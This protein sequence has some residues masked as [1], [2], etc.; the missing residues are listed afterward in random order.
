MSQVTHPTVSIQRP[1]SRNHFVLATCAALALVAAIAAGM[2]LSSGSA[3]SRTSRIAPVSRAQWPNE[4]R[5]AQAVASA[6]VHGRR[7]SSA[8]A[9]SRS[10]WPNEVGTAQAVGRGQISRPVGARIDHRG[11]HEGSGQAT[12]LQARP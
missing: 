1:A 11:L 10:Q 7:L 12:G 2:A 9:A 8:T 6:T 4:A 3:P 5:T